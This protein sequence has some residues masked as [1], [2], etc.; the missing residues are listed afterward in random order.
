[1]V[2]SITLADDIP[3][4]T[5]ANTAGTVVAGAISG[6]KYCISNKTMNWWNAHTWCDAQGRRMFS[7]ED[8]GCTSTTNCQN[9]CPEAS[10]LLGENAKDGYFWT[11]THRTNQHPYSVYLPYSYTEHNYSLVKSANLFTVC[12]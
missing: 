6:H 8:C 7:L 3:S 11:S 5:C 2:P 10:Y 12:Y 1:M 4:E 9:R